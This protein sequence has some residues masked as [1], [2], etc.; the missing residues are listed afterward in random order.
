MLIVF[1]TAMSTFRSVCSRPAA[2]LP[3]V[4]VAS[5]VLAAGCDLFGREEQFG[6][7]RDLVQRI[8]EVRAESRMCGTKEF[9][10]AGSLTWNDRLATSALRHARDLAATGGGGHTGSD[11]STPSER[12]ADAGYEA[13]TSGEIVAVGEGSMEDIVR[14]WLDSPGHCA[15]MMNPNFVDAGGAVQGLAWTVD[16]GRPR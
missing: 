8:S 2:F 1:W 6:T 3:V 11:G 13:S 9:E 5:V 10:A 12:I 14:A 7:R 16:F 4:F 15:A